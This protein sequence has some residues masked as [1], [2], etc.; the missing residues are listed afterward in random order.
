M[1]LAYVV[2]SLLVVVNYLVIWNHVK[3][4][5]SYL[6]QQ[7]YVH[8]FIASE[9]EQYQIKLL[10]L[11]SSI[12]INIVFYFISVLQMKFDFRIEK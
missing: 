1:G 10:V 5:S 11:L 2:P 8:E 9:F 3:R 6:R 12:M 4:S 7:G